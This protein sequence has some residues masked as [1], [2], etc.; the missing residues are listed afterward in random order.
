MHEIG[1][2][3]FLRLTA[4]YSDLSGI[5]KSLADYFLNN[6]DDNLSA[7]FVSKKLHVSLSSLSRFSKKL[8][9]EG[10]RE[11]KYAYESYKRT[12]VSIEDSHHDVFKTYQR[13]LSN[14]YDEMSQT[15]LKR[16]SK[17][18]VNYEK[19][20]VY[21]I[22]SSGVAA[23]EMKIRFMRLGINI[24][25]ISDIHTLKMNKAVVDKDT[26]VIGISLSGSSHILS[27]LQ[28]AHNRY[29]KTVLITANENQNLNQFCDE[30]VRVAVIQNLDIGN[31]IS[32]QFPILLVTDVI[33]SHIVRS[34]D[35]RYKLI[36]RQT[37][38][39]NRTLE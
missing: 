18:F 17:L 2:S 39:K 16:I 12:S 4:V 37:L 22:G 9:Y 5:D 10:Y 13:L 20:F 7:D 15:Q 33:Y 8:G 28:D 30:I 6:T 32:P 27:A 34:D 3:L 23:D 14:N 31:V 24:Q 38:S 21:G 1:N 36:M 35:A 29:A 19:V 25:S 11:F 26:L